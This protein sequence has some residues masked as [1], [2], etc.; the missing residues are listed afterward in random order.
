MEKRST[1][2]KSF[3][4]YYVYQRQEVDPMFTN[5]LSFSDFPYYFS[6][7]SRL[8]LAMIMGAVIGYERA[9]KKSTAGLRTFSI[10][11]VAAALTMTINEYLFLNHHS[12]DITRLSAQVISGIGFLGMGSIILTS[13]NQIKG[14]TTAATLWATAILGIAI[15]AGMV[16]PSF[17]AFF[18]MMF[19][20]TVLSHI[21]KHLERYNRVITIYL[22][23]DK[24]LGMTQIFEELSTSGFEILQ[25]EKQK[26]T[27][28]G[29]LLLQLELDLKGKYLHSD[30]IY[31]LSHIESIHY[32]E[33]VRKL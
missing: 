19:I 4:G 12:G 3:I 32:I 18:I 28:E 20:I 31:Q 27:L 21:S 2:N 1:I 30:I 6:F 24:Q 14:L 26:N 25:L 7:A 15:G 9:S 5:F 16:L 11:C 17:I 23:V 8:L 29:D 13:R 22:E 10:V 33:E